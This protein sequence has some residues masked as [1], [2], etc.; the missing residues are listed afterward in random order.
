MSRGP[1]SGRNARAYARRI[2]QCRNKLSLL[3]SGL[4]V[5]TKTVEKL[6]ASMG[7]DH[8]EKLWLKLHEKSLRDHIAELRLKPCRGEPLLEFG[9]FLRRPSGINQR[10]TWR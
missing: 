10:L 7:L 1:G 6:D 3:R 8:G 9:E 4:A 5:L 2:E